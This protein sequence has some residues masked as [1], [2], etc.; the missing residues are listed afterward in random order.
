MS[1]I[2]P[3]LRNIGFLNSQTCTTRI[4]DPLT[5][6]CWAHRRLLA[7]WREA[8]SSSIGS[9]GATVVICSIE[10]SHQ[11]L[12]HMVRTASDTLAR[13]H[14]H[15]GIQFS[16]LDNPSPCIGIAWPTFLGAERRP[17]SP[18]IRALIPRDKVHRPSTMA[19]RLCFNPCSISFSPL[20]QSFSAIACNRS[21]ISSSV[22]VRNPE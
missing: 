10:K 16:D 18:R 3:L 14:A 21:S 19:S 6:I 8:Y 15:D 22:N 13:T 5:G 20:A 2:D 4:P 9:S 12:L 1:E 17:C 7:T 11:F